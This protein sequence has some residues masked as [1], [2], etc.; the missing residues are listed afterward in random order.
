MVNSSL[1]LP[2]CRSLTGPVPRRP[3][4]RPHPLSKS[5]PRSGSATRPSYY[6]GMRQ[7]ERLKMIDA[8]F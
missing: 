6:H 8:P 3:L 4:A 1:P 7:R 2:V 5:K